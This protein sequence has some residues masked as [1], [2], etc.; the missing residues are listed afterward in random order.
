MAHLVRRVEGRPK[1]AADLSAIDIDP[2]ERARLPRTAFAWSEKRAFPIH[3][4]EHTLLSCVYREG[5]PN[6]PAIVDH[7]LKEACAVFD[8]DLSVY[9]QLKT[10]SAPEDTDVFLLP[11]LRRLKVACA[12]DVKTAEQRLHT[13]GARL[14]LA[15]RTQAC[16]RLFA[17]AAQYGVTLRPETLQLAGTTVTAR[18]PLVDWLEARKEAAAPPYKESYHKLATA[19]RQAPAELRDYAEQAS[20]ADSLATLDKMAGLDVYYGK[21]LPDPMLTVFNTQKHASAGVMLAGQHIPLTQLASHPATFYADILGAD[22][23]RDA[24]DAQGQL[25]PQQLGQIL[26]TLPVDMQRLLVAQMA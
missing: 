15:H 11:T 22:I 9:G 12:A 17:K 23:T 8:V 3:T 13:E 5:L 25:D 19:A 4:R 6:V 20:L 14:T 18:Q 16:R 10:A 2:E 7:N 21:K 1:L 26:S 24:T